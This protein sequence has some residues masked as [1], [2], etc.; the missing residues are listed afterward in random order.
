M[1]RD[2][3]STQIVAFGLFAIIL[4][5]LWSN[6]ARGEVISA[7]LT[8][9]QSTQASH[10][11]T[12]PQ[13]SQIHV[14]LERIG[15][16]GERGQ[17]ITNQP[18]WVIV[19]GRSCAA[20]DFYSLASAIAM[21]QP[22]T[23]VLVLDWSEGAADNFPTGLN[24]ATWTPVVAEWTGRV[25]KSLGLTGDQVSLLGHSWGAYIAYD[26]A[27]N[28]TDNG[29]H[30]VRSIIALDPAFAGIGLDLSQF[31][32]S[33]V[34]DRSWAFYDNDLYGSA[35][36]A[37]TADESFSILLDSAATSL[38]KHW[39]CVPLFEHLVRGDDN[40]SR[41]FSIATL[42]SAIV[43]PSVLAGGSSNHSKSAAFTATLIVGKSTAG[44]FDLV[45]KLTYQL[46]GQEIQVAP[47]QG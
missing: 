39:A 32:F 25:L 31:N 24:G 20:S 47:A 35:Q 6:A 37:L 22:E 5:L 14:S 27:A 8:F 40:I 1:T 16:N 23:Q 13:H 11:V 36:V 9:S 38:V 12:P 46:T 18:T 15:P 34:A 10:F 29:H 19:H 42:E 33:A 43:N 3:T 44:A 41:V 21:R 4:A 30:G 2:Q 45:R 26:I 28:W 7:E 17:A